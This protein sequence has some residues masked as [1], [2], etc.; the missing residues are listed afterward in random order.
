V[1]SSAPAD[2]ASRLGEVRHRPEPDLPAARRSDPLA[3]RG[4]G[5]GL[6]QARVAAQQVRLAAVH[7]T[8]AHSTVE[9]PGHE[10]GAGGVEG[11]RAELGPVGRDAPPVAG[12]EVEKDELT[13]RV[14]LD[15]GQTDRDHAAPVGAGCKECPVLGRHLPDPFTGA[16]SR[17]EEA[18]APGLADDQ[19]AV[20]QERHVEALPRRPVVGLAFGGL[21]PLANDAAREEIPQADPLPRGWVD[22]YLAD[23]R[24]PA[25]RGVDGGADSSQAPRGSWRACVCTPSVATRTTAVFSASRSDTWTASSRRGPS[26]DRREPPRPDGVGRGP[27]RGL[28]RVFPRPRNNSSPVDRVA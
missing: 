21:G 7:G 1:P 5:H 26:D 24:A 23:R 6:H 9:S 17:V 13:C 14:G 12:R 2:V 19:A 25:A 27:A 11:Q 22:P 3:V 20:H 18:N 4:D 16:R 15:G 8:H 28:L 10:D